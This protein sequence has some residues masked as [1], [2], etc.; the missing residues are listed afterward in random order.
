MSPLNRIKQSGFSVE[1]ET[2]DNANALFIEPF[3]KLT[4]EQLAYLKANKQ[5]II[6]ELLT[7]TVYTPNGQALTT[8]ARNAEH[9][10]FLIRMNPKLQ[11]STKKG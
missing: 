4:A 5:A 11:L 9:K 6:D 8:L 1:V 10:A 3:D 7:T 2:V